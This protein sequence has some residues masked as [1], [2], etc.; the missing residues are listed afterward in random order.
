MYTR[1]LLSFGRSKQGGLVSAI[2]I[3]MADDHE[4]WRHEVRLLLQARPEFQVICEVSDGSEAVHKAEKL[5]PDLLLLDSGLPEING[6]EAARRIRRLSPNSRIVF[7]SGDNSLDVVK[8]ALSTGA[9][10]YVWKARAQQ[11]L[12]PAIDAVL[13]GQQFVS[14]MI[15]GYRF[16][17]S[18]GAKAPHRHEV[19]FYSRDS[20]FL[21]SLT[22]FIAAALEAG[23]VAVAI[24]TESHHEGLT[25]MLKARGVEV[26]RAIREGTY[27]Q[28]DAAKSLS[29]FMVNG[30]PDSDQFLEIVGGLIRA[31]AK[32]GKRE[33][34]RVAACGEI[35]PLLWAE[36]N[37][38]AAVR[39]EQITEQL[40]DTHEVDV[41]CAYTLD[42]FHDE[43]DEQVVQN[44][45]SQHS[46]VFRL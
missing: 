22:E 33:H 7:L 41:L 8:V 19:L 39:L 18:S 14:S 37:A 2:R 38:D 16:A 1:L 13:R 36:G 29:T 4:D 24:V 5:L 23:D 27:I 45:C 26:D 21:R 40:V 42:S 34:S 3:L 10:G 12:M 46:A 32:A 9:L 25:Q 28:V 31:A 44:I 43:K 35:S 15:K 20:V 6:I 30:M 17:G 11:D